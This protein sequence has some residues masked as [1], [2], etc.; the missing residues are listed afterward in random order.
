VNAC[1]LSRWTT[2]LV[3]TLLVGAAALPG[4]ASARGC[5]KHPPKGVP[6]PVPAKAAE[7]FSLMKDKPTRVSEKRRRTICAASDAGFGLDPAQARRITSPM[8]RKGAW[9]LVPGKTGVLLDTGGGGV[10]TT[11][12]GLKQRGWAAYI[13]PW[14]PK[15][16]FIGMAVDGFDT[17]TAKGI[18]LD[19]LPVTFTAP[20]AH[21][22]FVLGIAGADAGALTVELT[23]APP[24]APADR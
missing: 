3:L 24:P 14:G 10:G 18:G 21:N 17:I 19:G 23:N 2:A 5:G 9:F 15:A 6:G 1:H 20:I 12:A 22:V 13:V 8:G 7:L 4:A 11:Y 16:K